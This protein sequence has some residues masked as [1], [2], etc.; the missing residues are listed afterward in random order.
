MSWR[1]NICKIEWKSGMWEIENL[2]WDVRDG[3]WEAGNEDFELSYPISHFKIYGIWRKKL[4]WAPR[5]GKWE[6][7]ENSHNWSTPLCFKSCLHNLSYAHNS[8]IK[9]VYQAIKLYES[10]SL[11]LCVLSYSSLQHQFIMPQHEFDLALPRVSSA[12]SS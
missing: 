5:S 1:P 2:I 3:K 4:N 12:L 9:H 7:N 10:D 8:I 11:Y 6:S